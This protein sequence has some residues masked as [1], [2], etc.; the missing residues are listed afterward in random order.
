[1]GQTEDET[2]S[3]HVER[4][5][6]RGS[7]DERYRTA[8]ESCSRKGLQFLTLVMRVFIRFSGEDCSFLTME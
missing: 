2:G 4:S 1:M 7:R 3:D 6:F 5:R 8:N